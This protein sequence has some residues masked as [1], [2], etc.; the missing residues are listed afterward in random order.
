MTQASLLDLPFSGT[1]PQSRH[2]SALGAQDAARRWRG[3]CRAYLLLL[4]S[5]G[6]CSDW[7]AHLYLALERTTINARRRDLRL[8]GLVEAEPGQFSKGPSGVR[9]CRWQLTEQGQRAAVQA[10]RTHTLTK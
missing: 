4:A 1:T 7:D 6:P 10:L 9:N 2:C 5:H 3:Q 8:H